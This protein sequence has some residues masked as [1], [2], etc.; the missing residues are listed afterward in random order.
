MYPI[1][2]KLMYRYR[3]IHICVERATCEWKNWNWRKFMMLLTSGFMTGGRTTRQWQAGKL[4][5]QS[6]RRIEAVSSI[7]TS[8]D[9]AKQKVAQSEQQL[10]QYQPQASSRAFHNIKEWVWRLTCFWVE[11]QTTLYCLICCFHLLFLSCPLFTK[12]MCFLPLW[13]WLPVYST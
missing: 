2:L 3:Y 9:V 1:Q 12:G 11:Y 5:M 4:C 7:D 10:V 13:G 6:K 8:K